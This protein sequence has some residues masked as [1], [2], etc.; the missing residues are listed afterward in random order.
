MSERA[1]KH[2]AYAPAQHALSTPHLAHAGGALR[3]EAVFVALAQ[4]EIVLRHLSPEETRKKKE[5]KKKDGVT[6]RALFT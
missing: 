6:T 4:Q 5:K 1:C 3:G 2:M